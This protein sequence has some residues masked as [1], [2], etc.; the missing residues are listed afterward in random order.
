M[1]TKLKLKWKVSEARS[2]RYRSFQT[3]GWPSAYYLSGKPAAYISSPSREDYY[4]PNVKTGNHGPL[5]VYVAVPNDEG[6]FD[7]RPLN[8]DYATLAE[9]K[10]GASNF[11][12]AHPEM[13]E[14]KK[15]KFA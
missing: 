10:E 5:K 7:W 14:L 3:R 4:P 9:A 8:R 12:S 6:S 15:V 13:W 1:S 11:L 2:G